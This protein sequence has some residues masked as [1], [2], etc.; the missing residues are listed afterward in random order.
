[1]KHIFT[2]PVPDDQHVRTALTAKG[3]GDRIEHRGEAYVPAL[4][5]TVPVFFTFADSFTT[6]VASI[7]DGIEISHLDDEDF[8]EPAKDAAEELFAALA[9]QGRGIEDM[10]EHHKANLARIERELTGG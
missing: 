10:L 1:M 5:A 9:E 4:E 3:Y 6:L 2:I 8:E 7:Q